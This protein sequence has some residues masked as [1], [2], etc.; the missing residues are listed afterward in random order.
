[1]KVIN[2]SGKRKRALAKARLIEGSGQ[3]R[4]NSQSL[5]TYQPEFARLR[6]SEPLKIADEA[7]KKVDIAVSTN[8]GGWQG[9]AEAARLAIAR[10][11]VK[12]DKK[13]KERFLKYD[14]HLLIA[15]VRRREAYKPNDSKARAAR[16]FSKR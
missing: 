4:I 3:I 15:D 13:L 14:R 12:Y 1:M 9:Q 2:T 16:Q 6:I 5:D 7:F 8:G 10:A 11:L